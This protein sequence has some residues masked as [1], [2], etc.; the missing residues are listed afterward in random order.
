MSKEGKINC[1]VG[2]C[3]LKRSRFFFLLC[4]VFCFAFCG[5]LV[6]F[7]SSSKTGALPTMREALCSVPCNGRG[8]HNT[9]TLPRPLP[10][11]GD[12]W[13]SAV[14]YGVVAT[15]QRRQRS[16]T[17]GQQQKHAHTE[18]VVRTIRRRAAIIKGK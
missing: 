7:I 16:K 3:T 11:L 1:T 9:T 15:Q 14:I 12:G 17:L 18:I 5:V 13:S 6:Y 4:F 10:V 2:S 8:H